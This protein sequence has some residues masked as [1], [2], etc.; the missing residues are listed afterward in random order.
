MA[1]AGLF[2]SRLALAWLVLGEWRSHPGRFAATA[3]AIA[4]GVVLGFAVHLVNGSALAS[5]EAAVTGVN[6][7]ADLQ[8][9][10]RTPLGFDERLYPRVA[11]AP[12][13][14]DASPVITLPARARNGRFTL[15]GVDVIRAGA[16]TPSLVGARPA[17]PDA[18]SDDIFAEDGLYL[19]RAALAAVGARVGDR[20]AVKANGRTARL[21]VAGTLPAT[22]A[23]QALGTI[24]I[25][26]AQWRFGRLGRIDRL[27]LKL[28]DRAVAE[29][30]LPELLGAD[31]TIRSGESQARQGDALS[32]AYRVNLDMLA[33][34]ALLTGGF[35]VFSAQTLSVTRR[36]RAFALV[37]TLG[38]PRAGIVAAV[39]LEGAIIG[40]VGAA[41]GLAAGYAMAVAALRLLGGDLGGGY[42]GGGAAHIVFQPVAAAT[43]FALG[44]AAALLGSVLPA[45][46][47]ARAA[48]AAA[49]KNAGDILDPRAPVPWR[50]ALVL[51][52]AGGGAA[53]LPAVGGLPL[54]GF[55]SMALLL[56]GG[57]AGVPWL[58]RW[59]LAPWRGREIAS[60]PR[61][62]AI[63]HVQGA[64]GQAAIA[65]C[66]IV[67]STA[68]MIA[69]ATMVTSFRGAVD[70]WLGQVLSADLYLRAESGDLDPAT[71]RRIAAV[72]GVRRAAFS[73]Q[74]P[75]TI[76]ADR[77]PVTLIAR[78][79]HGDV[80]DPLLVLLEEAKVPAGATPIWTSEPAARLYGWSPGR[81]VMLPVGGR[82]TRFVVAGVWRD[83][84]RQQGAVVIRD[85]DYVRLTGDRGRD[86]A[87][88][89]LAPGADPATVRRAV[90]AT[91]PPGI[92]VAEP[93]TLR[94]FALQLFDRSFAITYGLE[95]V[96]ILV[97]LAGV[98][99]TMSAQTIA[100]S[101]EFGM[102]RHLGLT[103]G[104]VTAMLASEGALLGLIGA[105]AGVAL[106]A[107]L[108]QVLIH[109]VNPQSFNWTMTT[110]WPF[111]TIAGVTVALTV[112]AALTAMLA[113][114]RATAADA[115]AAVREDW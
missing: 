58:V 75:L 15:L 33:L 46:S 77:P 72:A 12:G 113:G 27:D 64:P 62:L 41:L 34:V 71:Q 32:R 92:S 53:L 103:R 96:A 112:A 104:Q 93:A 38:L 108:G 47:A 50:P 42:F 110:I 99:A 37:R 95:A 94:R 97:G 111:A 80:E 73:R 56:A 109:V 89:T 48:P 82:S 91:L 81:S 115:V 43:F 28:G 40:I 107:L 61:L 25:A 23:G 87:A 60:V 114:R 78:P 2:R 100:R 65:L 22:P 86:E 55:A 29:R 70:G 3:L 106:G 4:V 1:E 21:R 49:L 35:L 8:V 17:G 84:A 44:V 88:I 69:M 7:A 98:A 79:V 63:R 90:A 76:V 5:F 9:S 45:R 83:Y 66:G 14:A 20:V 51:L 57:I 74:L 13:V 105:V 54:F 19:S 16:V 31:A 85:V 11:T 26:A 18:R 52:I 6:G 67:A 24:D 10:A 102:L 68:L 36:L 39:A 59:L 30:A 101:K